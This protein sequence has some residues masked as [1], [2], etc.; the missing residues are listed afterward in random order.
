[1]PAYSIWGGAVPPDGNPAQAQDS[2]A[3]TVGTAFTV[4]EEC[5]ATAIRFYF[6]SGWT[7]TRVT[8]VALYQAGNATPLATAAGPG[9][10]STVGWNDIAIAATPLTPGTT[11]VAA[12]HYALTSPGG[13]WPRYSALGGYFTGDR[14]S[15]ILTAPGGAATNGRYVYGST[16]AEPT[17][18]FNSSSYYSDVIVETGGSPVPLTYSEARMRPRAY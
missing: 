4:S 13:D 9:N 8:A 3:L 11:Y 5:T 16:I 1:M 18:E 6:G 7:T 10:T 17:T 2:A 12:V 15:G 14:I